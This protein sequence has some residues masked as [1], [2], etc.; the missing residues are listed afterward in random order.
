MEMKI[1]VNEMLSLL[2]I[3]RK[4]A[5]DSGAE[6][7]PGKLWIGSRRAGNREQITYYNGHV[8]MVERLLLTSGVLKVD[9]NN[10]HYIEWFE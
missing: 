1:D 8:N 2:D 4:Y 7:T 9:N 3:Q 10:K 6:Y 5:I